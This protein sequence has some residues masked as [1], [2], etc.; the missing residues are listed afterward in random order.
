MRKCMRGESG[1]ARSAS[2]PAPAPGEGADCRASSTSLAPL[3][4]PV[5]RYLSNWFNT[6]LNNQCNAQ[7]QAHLHDHLRGGSLSLERRGK[8][9]ERSRARVGQI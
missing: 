4:L 7:Q 2:T 8:K 3:R 9:E 6:M 1:R 5:V